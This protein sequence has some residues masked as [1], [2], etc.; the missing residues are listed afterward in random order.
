MIK[1]NAAILMEAEQCPI[2]TRAISCDSRSSRSA[3]KP[4]RIESD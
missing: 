4:F 3:L 2:R 1:D